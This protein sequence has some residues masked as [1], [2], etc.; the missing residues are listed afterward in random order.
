MEP[1]AHYGQEDGYGLRPK[2]R[3]PL[4]V[5]CLQYFRTSV[6]AIRPTLMV[7]QDGDPKNVPGRMYEVLFERPIRWASLRLVRLRILLCP[8]AGSKVNKYG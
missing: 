7:H 5:E 4:S 8:D 2:I 1:T 6:G 3:P